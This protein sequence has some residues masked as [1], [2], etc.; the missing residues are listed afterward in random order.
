VRQLDLTEKLLRLRGV[1][2]LRILTTTDLAP[3]AAAMRSARF[4]KGEVLLHEDAA[5]RS[6][7]LLVTGAVTMRRHGLKLRTITAPGGVGFLS[8]HARTAGGTE[9]VA[10]ATTEAFE[11]SGDALDDLYEDHFSVLLATLRWV[12]ERLV[13]ET[14]EE[15]P[16]P[17]KP[18]DDGFDRL[19]GDAEL[20]VVERIFLLRRT[21]AFKN[22]NVNSIARLVRRMRELRAAPGQVIWR[23]GDRADSN[24]F[25][26]KG[27]M[28]TTWTNSNGEPR[29]QEL[30]PGYV[31]GGGESMAGKPRWN[32]LVALE[33]AVMLEGT[34][35]ALVDMFE[36]DLE[37]AKTF[38]S[39][40]S[41]F[42]IASWD[43]KAER[44]ARAESPD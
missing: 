39:L 1:P 13:A 24:L 8:L 16:P 17:F 32:E 27:R 5:P 44:E 9:A 11:V 38:L 3:L 25:I 23:P 26:V 41:T 4:E 28:Q 29:V 10:E 19:I 6:F 30:G 40:L 20:G 22:A 21:I 7:Y 35:E 43:R 37:A 2:T 14:M 36:D 34:R 31:V 12:T 33:P 42:L 15:V 18:P